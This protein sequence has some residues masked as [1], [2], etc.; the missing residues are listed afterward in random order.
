M[1]DEATS[2]LDAANEENLYQQLLATNSTPVS[3]GHRA[4][5]LRF[6][7]QVL[8]LSGDGQWRTQAAKDYRFNA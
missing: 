8:E 2:A 6:H 7:Q 1:L 4:T 5:L 3:V